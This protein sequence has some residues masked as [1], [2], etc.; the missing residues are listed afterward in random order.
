VF[1]A[2]AGAGL[3]GVRLFNS[4]QR[5]L[6][7]FLFSALY[8]VGMLTSSAFGVS[9]Y[10]LS[11]NTVPAAGPDRVQ[12]GGGFLWALRWPGL[13][14]PRNAAGGSILDVRVPAPAG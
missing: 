1:P 13:V 7:A 12:R 14:D 10:V 4:Q 8:L 9:P 11:S 2:L 6:N 3:A 5:D